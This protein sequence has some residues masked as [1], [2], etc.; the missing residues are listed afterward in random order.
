MATIEERLYLGDRAREVLENEA[1]SNALDHIKKDISDQ[2]KSSP[3]RDVDGREKLWLMLKL[4]EKLEAHLKT[5]L[6]TGK[7]AKI[8][9]EH[10]NKLQLVKDA[11]WP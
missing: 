8:E 7:L 5:T 10:R 4:A 9:M 3:A 1:F 11:I 2:W 6:E